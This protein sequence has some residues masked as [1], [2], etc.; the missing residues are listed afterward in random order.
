MTLRDRYC[1]ALRDSTEL[2]EHWMEGRDW[3]SIELTDEEITQARAAAD[4]DG[5]TLASC[6]DWVESECEQVCTCVCL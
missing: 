3:Y 5:I 1:R 4:R 6:D 2:Y